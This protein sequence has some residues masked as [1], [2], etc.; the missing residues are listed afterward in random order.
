MCSSRKKKASKIHLICVYLCIHPLTLTNLYMPIFSTSISL[1]ST[2]SSVFTGIISSSSS[3]I[4]NPFQ[5]K[6]FWP[7][8]K[9][10]DNSIKLWFFKLHPLFFS[11]HPSSS[12]SF[13]SSLASNFGSVPASVSGTEKYL[14]LKI[15]LT[16]NSKSKI[17]KHFIVPSFLHNKTVLVVCFFI[18]LL[19]FFFLWFI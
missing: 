3:S 5:Q 6:S 1:L 17:K 4:W 2:S 9:Q 12:S 10:I 15:K 14:F 16:D 7:V 19:P 18:C 8:E 11:L 13:S